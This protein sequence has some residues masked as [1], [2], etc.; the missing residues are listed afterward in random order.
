LWS[1]WGLDV[2]LIEF[3]TRYKDEIVAI[4]T[5]FLAVFAGGSI[6]IAW[7]QNKLTRTLE[8]AYLAIKPLGIRPLR[9]DVGQFVGY[10]AI[11]N[12][13]HSP[14]K[15]VRWFISI[16]TAKG[17]NETQFP[18]GK[19]AGDNFLPRGVEMIQGSD[20]ISSCDILSELP[21]NLYFYVWGEIKFNDGSDPTD[22]S[23]FAT[24]TAG[25]L[26]A[27]LA[28]E[29]CMWILQTLAITNMETMPPNTPQVNAALP[30]A[31]YTETRYSEREP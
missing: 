7:Q 8:R 16:K 24:A 1:I 2:H 10:I 3:V 14:A 12:V 18:I 21:T 20:S 9:S 26:S 4:A 17:S 5:L 13:G 22:G 19:H 29:V 11:E 23:N 27:M 28:D 6:Y 31:R 15:N 25:I 30:A